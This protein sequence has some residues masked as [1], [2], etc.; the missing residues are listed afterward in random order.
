M[1]CLH[2]LHDAVENR[3]LMQVKVR[4]IGRKRPIKIPGWEGVRGAWQGASA[5]SSSLMLA[6]HWHMLRTDPVAEDNQ[7]R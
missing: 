1:E 3:R 6:G 4:T 2:T 5:V 7:H